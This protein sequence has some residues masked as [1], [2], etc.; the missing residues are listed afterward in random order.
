MA[1]ESDAISFLEELCWHQICIKI[2]NGPI[3][4]KAFVAHLSGETG[5]PLAERWADTP[6][7]YSAI[8]AF[9]P[10]NT[11]FLMQSPLTRRKGNFPRITK[12]QYTNVHSELIL[13]SREEGK[14]QSLEDKRQH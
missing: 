2:S 6:M 3:K 10:G 9:D 1:R 5:V 13:E 8:I 14:L 4:C 11:C 7:Q 12:Q